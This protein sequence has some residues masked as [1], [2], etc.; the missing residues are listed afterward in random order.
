MNSASSASTTRTVA[1][2]PTA[3]NTL[4]HAAMKA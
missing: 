3:R 2:R 1:D 4:S